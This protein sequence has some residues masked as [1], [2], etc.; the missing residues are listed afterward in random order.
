MEDR[1]KSNIQAILF[2]YEEIQS[3]MNSL[4]EIISRTGSKLRQKF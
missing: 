4:Q 3:G 2:P 1:S